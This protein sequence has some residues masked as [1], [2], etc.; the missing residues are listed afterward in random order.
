MWDFYLFY[1]VVRNPFQW[2]QKKL[3]NLSPTNPRFLPYPELS[4]EVNHEIEVELVESSD[5]MTLKD[6]LLLKRI[7][8]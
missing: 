5:D 8:K 7:L 3:Q 6:F 2:H 1:I 4:C